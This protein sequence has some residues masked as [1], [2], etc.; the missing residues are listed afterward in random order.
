MKKF[1]FL[2]LVSV[3]INCQFSNAQWTAGT[4]TGVYYLNSGNA[5]IGTST[6]TEK[7]TVIG[8]VSIPL[9][10]SFGFG[11][12][13][14]FTYDSKSIGNYT[15]GWY[16]DSGN[17]GAPSSYYSSYGGIKFFTQTVPRVT[18]A[19][20]GN[21]GMGTTTPASKLEIL[22]DASLISLHGTGFAQSTP[23]EIINLGLQ[24]G[25]GA[26]NAAF[27]IGY[28]YSMGVNSGSRLDLI[29][30]S[31]GNTILGTS[32]AGASL[33]NIGIGTTIPDSKLT[34][35]G[36][37]HTQ[38][39][40]VDLSVPGPDYVFETSY[41]LPSLQELN[42]YIKLNRHLPEVP[43]ARSMEENGVKLGEMNMLLLKK[44]EELT[45][46]VIELQKQNVRQDE[47]ISKLQ[48]DKK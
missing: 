43:S 23:L 2:L 17:T 41:K 40:K 25:T 21:V 5:G 12:S 9:L 22:G 33:G 44:V 18:I 46:Y 13:D 20:N 42:A 19:Q 29:K 48:A 32:E 30:I 28:P 39:V 14:K 4:P 10:S 3:V 45:L 11:Q 31:N 6:P 16:M 47:I 15:L 7:L 8:N 37:I 36:T 27:R 26:M 35:K 24:G 38:E 1:V 34:V